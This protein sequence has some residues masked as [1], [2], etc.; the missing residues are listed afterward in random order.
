MTSARIP[1]GFNEPD[2]NAPCD[3]EATAR[4]VPRTAKSKGMLLNGILDHLAAVG[5]PH[6]TR[7]PYV[8]FKD[9][10]ALEHF[11]LVIEAARTLHPA[12]PVRQGVRRVGHLTYSTLVTSM[13][14]KVI[15]GVLGNDM[16]AVQK[17]LG[18]AYS[19]SSTT[20]IAH[21]L[22]VAHDRARARL[23]EIPFLIDSYHVG[24]FEGVLTRLQ[25]KGRV[26]Y[27]SLGPHGGE[28]LTIWE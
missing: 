13:I 6:P 3:L 8:A 24:F 21:V 5:K 26:F 27:K 22:E 7:A 12:L 2:W 19:L 20:G 4:S 14:G 10:P 25:R 16:Q 23:D 18:K 11:E 9:Y 28:V 17:Q 15:F 1:E